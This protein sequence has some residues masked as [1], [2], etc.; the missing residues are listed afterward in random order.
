[1]QQNHRWSRRRLPRP[2]LAS[3]LCAS[4]CIAAAPADASVDDPRSDQ[5][6]EAAAAVAQLRRVASAL[7]AADPASASSFAW[8]SEGTLYSPNQG[9]RPGVAT[10]WKLRHR[11]FNNFEVGLTFVA[12]DFG[13]PESSFTRSSALPHD[14]GAGDLLEL[15][16]PFPLSI[17]RLLAKRP[18]DLR[19]VHSG[20]S[21]AVIAGPVIDRVVEMEVGADGLPRTLSYII[22]DPVFGDSV[23]RFE[24]LDYRRENGLVFAARVRQTDAGRPSHDMRVSGPAADAPRPGWSEGLTPRQAHPPSDS[25][26]FRAEMIAPGI[27]L[28]RQIGGADYHALG[29]DLPEGWMVLETPDVI[30]D[31]AEVRSALKAI[32]DKPIVY[33]APTH[34]HDDHSSGLVAF[35]EDDVTVLTTP[36]NVDYFE[37]MLAAQRDF[38]R[39]T[40]RAR[41]SAVTPGP[42]IG[43]VRFLQIPALPHVE[44]M[45][46]FYFPEHRILFHSDLGRFNQNGPPEPARAQSCALLGL[47][48]NGGIQVDRIYSG[49]GVPGTVDKLREAIALRDSP[50]P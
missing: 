24:Y 16:A 31:G 15:T 39:P 20:G 32:A 43:P 21:G 48:E 2:I 23:R 49:H 33:A 8:Q 44:E 25:A 34:H 50:C 14:S 38:S 26:G 45:L 12:L 11:Q 22:T 3:V 17:V 47:I 40:V 36:G 7:G 18:A 37:A 46:V 42:S 41:V 6:S 30:A 1:M 10:E 13:G 5:I 28:L 4:L 29:V 9:P 27:H 35:A 19:L